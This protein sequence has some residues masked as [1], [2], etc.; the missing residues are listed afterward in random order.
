MFFSTWQFISCDNILLLY[1]IW[2]ILKTVESRANTDKIK[3]LLEMT[4]PYAPSVW[5][6][7][8]WWCAAWVWWGRSWGA[9]LLCEGPP[10]SVAQERGSL[11]SPLSAS[12]ASLPLSADNC[13][14]SRK[15]SSAAAV[16]EP[17]VS[18]Q[19]MNA[20]IS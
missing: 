19:R 12:V 15:L 3:I 11:H 2:H 5:G 7:G 20:S 14:T 17:R 8:T 16:A 4:T 18:V 9:C 13:R 1:L 10:G 6:E